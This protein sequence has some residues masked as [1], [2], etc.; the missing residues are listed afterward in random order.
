LA[1]GCDALILLTEWNEFKN[2]DF[3]RIKSLMKQPI[4]IDGR[5]LYNPRLMAEAG[6]ISRG[7][8]RG[9]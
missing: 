1:E 6:F 9:Y 3:P 8:G 4:L 7:V 5:K 2:L